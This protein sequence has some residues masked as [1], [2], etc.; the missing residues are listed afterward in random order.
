MKREETPAS[1]GTAETEP[2]P[3]AE[4]DVGEAETVAGGEAKAVY[5][6]NGDTMAAFDKFCRSF[7][8]SVI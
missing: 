3:G 8:H 7:V 4:R 2:P 6:T 1:M 5:D